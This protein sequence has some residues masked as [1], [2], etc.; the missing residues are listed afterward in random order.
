MAA[1]TMK[2]GGDSLLKELVVEA[3]QERAFRVFTERLDAWWARAH[4]NG[5]AEM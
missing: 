4:P 1:T 5:K 2:A 3:P